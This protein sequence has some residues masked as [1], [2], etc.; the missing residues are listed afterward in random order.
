[1]V[2]QS[3]L[4]YDKD[5]AYVY[6]A[7][8]DESASKE[9]DLHGIAE[10]RRIVLGDKVIGSDQAVVSGLKEGEPVVIQGNVKIQNNSQIKIGM[11]EK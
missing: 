2:P 7:K 11:V 1:M 6:I 4:N 3:A 5:G 10:Q 9:N 8:I